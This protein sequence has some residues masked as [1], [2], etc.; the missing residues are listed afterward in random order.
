M[1][2]RRIVWS[3]WVWVL[4]AAAMANW[5][6]WTAFV[7]LLA[8]AFIAFVFAPPEQPP[9][10]GLDH[11]FTIAS[12]DFLNTMAGATNTPFTVGNRIEILNNGDEFYPRMLAD[13]ANAK[14]SITMEAY[15]YW[16]G[17]VGLRFATALAAKAREGVIVKLLL[18]AVG[19]SSISDEILE[20]LTASG[21]KVA[22]FHPIHWYSI[23]R[24][25]NRTH[26]KSLII[27]GRLGYTGGAGIADHW[28]GHAQDADHWRDVQVRIQ[29]P[30]VTPLQSGFAQNWLE[31]TSEL[32]TGPEYY[33]TPDEAGT[34]PVQCDHELAGG[35]RV[36]RSDAVLPLDRL[37]PKV[38]PRREPVFH[39]GRR[40]DRRARRREEARR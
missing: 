13:I 40:G 3:W 2:G 31:T 20:T 8:V 33:P 39:P 23:K 25:N 4:A 16:A 18:D 36:L 6:H 24:I 7:V 1:R 32:V 37:R 34:L 29:G 10:Y 11:E 38:H 5:R 19:S 12:D 9:T 14:E 26:R 27:D 28:L 30:A 15:I 22:W 17:D 35:R 21:C